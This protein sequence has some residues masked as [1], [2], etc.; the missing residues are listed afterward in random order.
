[1]DLLLVALAAVGAGAVNTA[2]GSG[3]L[4]TYPALLLAGLPPVAA[5]V[6]NTIGL[7]PGALAGAWAFRAELRHQRRIIALLLPLASLGAVAGAG[8][9]LVLPSEAFALIVPLLVIASACLV[10]LQ[11][12][13]TRRVRQRSGQRRGALAVAVTGASVYGGYFSAAQGI[14][15]LGL[16][17]LF[18][19]GD[20]TTQNALK[21]LLQASVNVVAACFFLLITPFD[22]LYTAGVAV[23]SLLGAPL[24]AWLARRIQPAVFRGI[25]VVFG[26]TVGCVLLLR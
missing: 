14:I 20:L 2:V 13:L 17:G 23:G 9:L 3:S 11:P 7:A 21:N 10:G 25:V 8:L 19:R 4:I 6:T 1:M 5:N 15:L 18:H 12:L 26:L 22:P 16:L 24:G